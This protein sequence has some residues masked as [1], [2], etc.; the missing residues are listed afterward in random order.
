MLES[1]CSSFMTSPA[2]SL[3]GESLICRTMIEYPAKL[4]HIVLNLEL[5][6][7]DATPRRP[8]L[9]HA[10]G[11]SPRVRTRRARPRH[12]QVAPVTSRGSAGGETQRA[13]G[14]PLHTAVRGHR[15]RPR[16]LP[17]CDRDADGSGRGAR[18]G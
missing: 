1:M 3:V 10:G 13:P 9:L 4:E 14:E 2:G 17:A 6:D 5:I 7:R 12:P 11:R 16:G 15:C 8:L 18:G